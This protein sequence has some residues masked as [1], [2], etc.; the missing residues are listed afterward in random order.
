MN[1]SQVSNKNTNLQKLGTNFQK[2]KNP[3]F[4]KTAQPML[5]AKIYVIE[6]NKEVMQKIQE[7]IPL[8]RRG[9]KNYCN[10]L[11]IFWK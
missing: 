6:H 11:T 8:I 10:V 9:Q 4:A 3:I 7:P 2:S 1:V 5:I